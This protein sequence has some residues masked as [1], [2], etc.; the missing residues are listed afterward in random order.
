MQLWTTLKLFAWLAL[1]TG[2][3]YPAFITLIAQL[4]MPYQANG[5]LISQNN[6]PV[7]YRL[8]GQK[9]E[10][11]KYFWPRPSAVDYQPLPSGGSNLAPTS[12]ELKKLVKMRKEKFEDMKVPSEL[13]YASASGV[14]PHISPYSALFQVKRI[15]RARGISEIEIE[16]VLQDLVENRA[17]SLGK[18][19]VNVLLLNLAL[20]R[21]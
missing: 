3:L 7:G 18:P 12:K 4:T 9:F 10:E 15:A 13:L 21:K 20:D 14:D 2:V 17:F 19:Y 8:I 11:E 16:E 6:K 1:L 5:S